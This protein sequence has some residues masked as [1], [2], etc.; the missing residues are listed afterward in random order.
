MDMSSLN[1]MV[2]DGMLDAWDGATILMR[3]S[4]YSWSVW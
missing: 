2:W 1:P 4:Y 3:D